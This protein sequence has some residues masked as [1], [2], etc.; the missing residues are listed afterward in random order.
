MSSTLTI[1][2]G[3]WSLD[4]FGEQLIATIKNGKSFS[5]NPINSN[6]NALNTRATV[7]SN[8]PTRSVMSLVS[9]RD[10]HL[11]MLGTETTV[12]DT[13]TQD[14]LFIRFSDQENTSDYTPTSVNTAGTFRVDQ[15]TKI[16]GA[17]Q[18]KDYTLILTDNAAYWSTRY[19]IC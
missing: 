11:I 7:I 17:V 4:N 16:V 2:P 3:S 13:S 12:G 14:K 6:A 15:G 9:D 10:R 1:D 8:A 18:G 19:E 5:W